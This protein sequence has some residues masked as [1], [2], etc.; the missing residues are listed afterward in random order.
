[1]TGFANSSRRLVGC[2]AAWQPAPRDPGAHRDDDRA[3]TV[4]GLVEILV[5]TAAPAPLRRHPRWENIVSAAAR[6]GTGGRRKR[7]DV[8]FEIEATRELCERYGDPEE[9]ADR[10]SRLLIWQT[11]PDGILAARLSGQDVQKGA[12]AMGQIHGGVALAATH[13]IKPACAVVAMRTGGAAE[14]ARRLDFIFIRDRIAAGGLQWVGYRGSDRVA[15]DQ[16]SAYSLYNFLEAANTDLYLGHS[17]DWSSQNDKLMIGTL[18]VIGQFERGIIRERTHTATSRASSTPAAVTPASNRSAPAATPRCTSSR[19]PSNGPTSSK[20][21]R[22]TTGSGPTAARASASSLR[23]SPRSSASRSAATASASSSKIP[24]TSPARRT[25]PTR[26]RLPAASDQARQS[27][28]G[29][30]LRTQP[31]VHGRRQGTPAPN[32]LGHFLLNRIEFLHDTCQHHVTDDGLQVR[33]RGKDKIYTTT[34][35]PV[36]RMPAI[37]PPAQGARRGER[38]RAAAPLR[39]P[40]PATPLPAASRADTANPPAGVLS[41]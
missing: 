36:P 11:D 14:Y 29:R 41:P 3:E 10:G 39:R 35:L 22:C 19:T 27:G 40:R 6:P 13:G 17:V 32:A 1:V 28:P 23:F 8:G 18:G 33:L 20:P 5:G 37:H 30:D 31:S 15:R 2:P 4:C 9:I 12:T 24:S 38:R 26:G 16:L 25:S 34:A 21:A 7:V